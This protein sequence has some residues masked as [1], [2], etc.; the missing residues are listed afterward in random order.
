MWQKKLCAFAST[1]FIWATMLSQSIV[2]N[3]KLIKIEDSSHC[4]F[5]FPVDGKCS[6]VCGKGESR[7]RGRV[8]Q[9]TI[10]GLTTAFLLWQTGIDQN[11]ETWWSDSKQNYQTLASAGYIKNPFPTIPRASR[12]PTVTV[13]MPIQAGRPGISCRM[14]MAARAATTGTAERNTEVVLAPR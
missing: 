10:L 4:H 3:S 1:S 2:S 7:F 8:I 5:E 12:M 11:G 13:I 9:Q 6:L 14:G